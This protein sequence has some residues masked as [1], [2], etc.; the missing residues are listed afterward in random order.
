MVLGWAL[1]RWLDARFFGAHGYGTAAGT[2]VGVY[3]G[4]RALWKA[5]KMMQREAEREDERERQRLIDGGKE[6][7]KDE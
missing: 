6:A 2:I 4:F 7:K 3:A 1:G 5:A